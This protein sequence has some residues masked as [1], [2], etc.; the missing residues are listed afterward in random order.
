[1]VEFQKRHFRWKLSR[2]LWWSMFVSTI[3]MKKFA[4]LQKSL[5]KILEKMWHLL[6]FDALVVGASSLSPEEKL[7]TKTRH[8]FSRI[9]SNDFWS[10]ANF[11]IEIVETNIDHHKKRKRLCF[12]DNV[13]NEFESYA[14]L[15]R[16]RG[17]I[18]NSSL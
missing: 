6:F 15:R 16:R 17:C 2:I 7:I 1:M 14:I 12:I 5:E 8:I 10:S 3:S 9:F 4:E 11:F 18:K 13:Q